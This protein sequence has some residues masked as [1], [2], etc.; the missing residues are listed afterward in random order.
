MYVWEWL[1]SGFNFK[2][3]AV[4][5]GMSIPFKPYESLGCS[6]R[7]SG[8]WRICVPLKFPRLEDAVVLA[9]VGGFRH[10]GEDDC[11]SLGGLLLQDRDYVGQ[12]A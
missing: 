2:R 12:A 11:G 9:T 4:S 7:F 8:G 6:C 3:L 1:A 10:A 5:S